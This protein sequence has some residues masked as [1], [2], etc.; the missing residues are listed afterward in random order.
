ML[1][2]ATLL[3]LVFAPAPAEAASGSAPEADVNPDA[4][5]G[6]GA[7]EVVPSEASTALP[8]S[9]GSDALSQPPPSDWRIGAFVD[10]SYALNTNFPDNGVYRG[11]ATTPRANEFSIPAAGLYLVKDADDES[12]WWI[13]LGVHAGSGV[14]ALA[15]SELAVA[16]PDVAYVGPEVFKH[17]A[18]ANGGVVFDS[19]TSL[20]A[21]LFGSPIG[22]GGFWSKDNW[23]YTPSW[24]SNGAAF[25]LAGARVTQE[26]PK[27]FSAEAWVVNGWQIN[28][29]ANHVPSY[30]A[31]LNWNGAGRRGGDW[32]LSQQVY[33]GPEGPTV[34]P[35]AWRVHVD[36]QITYQREDWGVGFVWDY[37]RDGPDAIADSPRATWT[38]GA[39]FLRGR[40]F[41]SKHA[42][43]FVAARPEVWLDPN[44]RIF[45]A[46]QTLVSATGTLDWRLYDHVLARVEYRYDHSTAK[47][48][49]FYANGA[50]NPDAEGLAKN[51]HNVFFAL[52]AMFEH[53]FR[54]RPAL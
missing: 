24:E 12:P 33:F 1:A 51:Q 40:V 15:S 2:A 41:D 23:N 16:G 8:D 28:A 39:L 43:A 54:Q 20:G 45:G 42:Q 37:G 30:L 25:Y 18:R 52:T 13:E 38:G 36:S 49:Y 10:A 26:L 6:A 44:G 21:G 47:D 5:A 48:G 11:T 9:G 3:G 14:D 34:K 35:E 27:G 17:L 53:R 22:I 4:P 31:A 29:D 7:A 46:E 32:F 50:T 19:G